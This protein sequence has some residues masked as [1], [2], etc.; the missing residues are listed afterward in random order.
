MKSRLEALYGSG[1]H[2]KRV[3]RPILHRTPGSDSSDARGAKADQEER[4]TLK[5]S[6]MPHA[7]ILPWQAYS[8]SV[9][10]APSHCLRRW[11]WRR[12]VSPVLPLAEVR[13]WRE[14]PGATLAL[15]GEFKAGARDLPKE[16][17]HGRAGA[18][19]A[20]RALRA[21]ADHEC[22]PDSSEFLRKLRTF[23]RN[24]APL[25]SPF[26]YRYAQSDSLARKS[27]KARGLSQRQYCRV[28]QSCRS[29]PST[30]LGI[31]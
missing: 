8:A 14:D 31:R 20:K 15:D 28:E 6:R 3:D 5:R 19:A 25:P 1:R 11:A 17:V 13:Q 10:V 29:R 30:K 9:P 16:P 21:S 24:H 22:I 18:S 26:S 23:L 12:W 2:G 27:G 4:P 7:T